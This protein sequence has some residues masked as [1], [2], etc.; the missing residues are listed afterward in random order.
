MSAPRV[1]VNRHGSV[2]ISSGGFTDTFGEPYGSGRASLTA[3]RGSANDA[4]MTS[5][6]DSLINVLEAGDT[7]SGQ[8]ENYEE[9]SSLIAKMVEEEGAYD[10]SPHPSRRVP[11]PPPRSGERGAPSSAMRSQRRGRGGAPPLA[12]RAGPTPYEL[13]ETRNP[14]AETKRAVK[15]TNAE[16][17]EVTARLARSGADSNFRKMKA[18]TS[19]MADELEGLTFTP[20]LY[21]KTITLTRGLEPLQSRYEVEI[22][23]RKLRLKQQQLEVISNELR[24]TTFE[25]DMSHTRAVNERLLAETGMDQMNVVDRC[26]EYGEEAKA[27]LRV[28]GEIMKRLEA[29]VHTFSPHVRAHQSALLL[30]SLYPAHPPPLTPS[31]PPSH[32][33]SPLARS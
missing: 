21:N 9:I 1:K 2:S 15:L 17:D 31:L 16:R 24:D 4:H 27:R 19:A 3:A 29:R 18:Q 12:L 33:P 30:P 28:R 13:W 8:G 7:G 6:V 32:V 26:M 10:N 22:E 11:P 23:H 14:T 25:P 20:K 5:A